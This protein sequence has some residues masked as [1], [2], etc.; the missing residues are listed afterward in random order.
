MPPHLVFIS[1]ASGDRWIATE[2]SKEVKAIGATSFVYEV[3]V[4]TGDAIPDVIQRNLQE[5]SEL[6]ALLTPQSMN[7]RW[8]WIEIGGAWASGKRVVGIV[9]GMTVSDF[10]A[11]QDMPVLLQETNLVHLNDVARYVRELRNRVRQGS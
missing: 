7:R 2:L 5:C 3:D 1:H 10:L 8:L 11:Q 4:E 6:V 9:H